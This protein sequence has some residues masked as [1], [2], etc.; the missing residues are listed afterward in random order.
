MEIDCES[1]TPYARAKG[2]EMGA[3]CMR[4]SQRERAEV[5]FVGPMNE[6][7]KKNYGVELVV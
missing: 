5:G 4:Q 3:V 2:Q 1:E 6:L 7:W